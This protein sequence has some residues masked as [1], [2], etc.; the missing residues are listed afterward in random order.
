MTAVQI[1]GWNSDT[2]AQASRHQFECTFQQGKIN[3]HELVKV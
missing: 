3:F 1:S 2:V